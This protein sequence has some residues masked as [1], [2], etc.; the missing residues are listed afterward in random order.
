M[1]LVARIV[2]TCDVIR[3]TSGMLRRLRR[4]ILCR[5]HACMRLMVVS[6]SNLRLV[7]PGL[8]YFEWVLHG[9]KD[10][11]VHSGSEYNKDISWIV[12]FINKSEVFLS[13]YLLLSFIQISISGEILFTIAISNMR[14][15]QRD[16]SCKPSYL[17]CIIILRYSDWSK[18]ASSVIML[19]PDTMLISA[20]G[21]L[22][23]EYNEIEYN[24]LEFMFNINSQLIQSNS[25]SCA[26]RV[27][28]W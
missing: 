14:F 24:T 21:N 7:I 9:C 16:S 20:S 27:Q 5:C 12:E 15:Y 10:N 18:K 2:A 13:I 23:D 22:A 26:L 8:R 25:N 11:Q 28:S 6:L 19:S 17:H 4:D 1:E 3:S